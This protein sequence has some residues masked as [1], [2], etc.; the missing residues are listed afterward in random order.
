MGIPVSAPTSRVL[1]VLEL[2]SQPGAER[3]RFSDIARE[4][5]LTQGTANAILGTLAERGWVE[6]DPVDKR[7]AIGGGLALLA[8]RAEAGRTLANQAAAA[9]RELAEETGML[10][11]L[12]ERVGDEI[13][14]LTYEGGA[15][16]GL[17]GSPGDSIPYAPPFGLTF[18]AWDEP[19]GQRAWMERA[20]LTPAVIAALDGLLDFTRDR[21]YSVEWMTEVMAEV[22]EILPA[23]GH[24]QAGTV[25]KVMRRVMDGLLLDYIGPE[26]QH[27]KTAPDPT[28]PVIVIS[29]PVFD[30]HGR[31]AY[32]LTLHPLQ[33]LEPTEIERLG[34]RLTEVCAS[35]APAGSGQSTGMS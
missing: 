14:I 8:V 11:N 2:L 34:A 1:D 23:L 10:V 31:V 30:Q 5:G 12:A 7:Y 28:T 6:R 4:L 15:P 20:T 24:A 3:L 9:S 32:G 29:A 35:L 19:E 27:F 17:R 16:G 22:A 18:A 21:G 26:S 25:S 33:P 13:A